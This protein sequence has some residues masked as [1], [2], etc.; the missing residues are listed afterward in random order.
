MALR[1]GLGPPPPQQAFTR[2]ND[3]S[4]TELIGLNRDGT[5][6]CFGINFSDGTTLDTATSALPLA[7]GTM[8][9][10]IVGNSNSGR[11]TNALLFSSAAGDV[12][13]LGTT[14]EG[15][16][17]YISLA[18]ENADVLLSDVSGGTFEIDANGSIVLDSPLVYF[19]GAI[20]DTN[21]SNGTDGQLLSST[22]TEILWGPTFLIGS[23]P[24]SGSS[25]NGALYTNK[26][27][28]HAAKTLLYVYDAATTTYIGI[29]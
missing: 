14:A 11:F 27:G 25:V 15:N 10:P 12:F 26:G 19:T 9:G 8:T 4:G 5:I 23:G 21:S 1:E 29:A 18:S 24:P 20:Q 3:P 22:G 13:Q 16:I 28:N 6:Y 17:I 2:W 7:G